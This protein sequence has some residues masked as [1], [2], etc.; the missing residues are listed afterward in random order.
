MLWALE[1][2]VSNSIHLQNGSLLDILRQS[3]RSSGLEFLNATFT[4]NFDITL[5]KREGSES[6]NIGGRVRIRSGLGLAENAL[7]RS[8]PS[9]YHNRLVLENPLRLGIF[10]VRF[11]SSKDERVPALLSNF[12]Q[13]LRLGAT[14]NLLSVRH[15]PI[16][17]P[18]P[19]SANTHKKYIF[20]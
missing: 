16:R 12:V 19:Y 14:K 3:V 4:D 1:S 6:N 8:I 10:F 7:K 9:P 2:N 17:I 20:V 11:T 5:L 18:W 13:L 15:K